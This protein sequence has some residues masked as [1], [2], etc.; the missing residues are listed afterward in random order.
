[1]DIYHIWCDLRS[2]VK[3]TDFTDAA[4][5]YLE[6]LSAAGHLSSFRI[7]RR[8][9]GLGGPAEFHLML[10]FENL[11]KLDKAFA[12]VATR[13]DPVEGF[14]YAVNSKVENLTAA[15]YRDFPDDFRQRGEE[16]F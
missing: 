15:L 12:T 13:T 9:L 14:H 2:G 5:T 10:E 1:M 11:D 4:N 8:K 16:K 6:A 3:D 7:T